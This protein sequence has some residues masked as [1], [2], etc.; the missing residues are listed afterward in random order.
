M[1]NGSVTPTSMSDQEDHGYIVFDAHY[2][3]DGDY[4][5]DSTVSSLSL[6][7]TS[8][9]DE[10]F[11]MNKRAKWNNVHE[12][13]LNPLD[14]SETSLTAD[15]A[16]G[17][18]GNKDRTSA[19]THACPLHDHEINANGGFR[20]LH[21]TASREPSIL[22]APVPDPIQFLNTFSNPQQAPATSP[23]PTTSPATGLKR[24][25]ETSYSKNE[26]NLL[27]DSIEKAF[28]NNAT[29]TMGVLEIMRRS[30][31]RDDSTRLAMPMGYILQ[32]HT[33]SQFEESP[34]LLNDRVNLFPS[35]IHS[36][37]V[38][39][40][41]AHEDV[42]AV[43]QIPCSPLGLPTEVDE[44]NVSELGLDDQDQYLSEESLDLQVSKT[45][46]NPMIREVL[47]IA[48]STMQHPFHIPPKPT[49]TLVPPGP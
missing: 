9:L 36:T 16:L 6:S 8:S 3:L 2:K 46:I 22:Q 41:L 11:P 25:R 26:I 7:L 42:P 33:S 10:Q 21:D 20:S 29:K 40:P 17:V 13:T 38:P 23:S 24:K 45:E 30:G 49:A 1:M 47:D 28:V 39:N 19:S 43:I 48:P 18:T 5:D 31:L 35:K 37:S 15:D 32:N 44:D 4:T 27:L 12:A 14:S 34:E